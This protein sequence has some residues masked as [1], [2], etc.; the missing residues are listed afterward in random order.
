MRF[1]L[2]RLEGD[3]KLLDKYLPEI[4]VRNENISRQFSNVHGFFTSDC[5]FIKVLAQ[6]LHLKWLFCCVKYQINLCCDKMTVKRAKILQSTTSEH[7]FTCV[8]IFACVSEPGADS[9][10]NRYL[11][12][13]TIQEL[14]QVPSVTDYF[15]TSWNSGIRPVKEAKWQELENYRAKGLKFVPGKIKERLVW[16]ANNKE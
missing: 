5:Y 9:R 4:T 11:H 7:L 1:I 2:Q 16:Y 14:A 12:S 8:H 3:K 13:S 15:N 10:W 6:R